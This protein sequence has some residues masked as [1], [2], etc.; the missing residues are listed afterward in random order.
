MTPQEQ[1]EAKAALDRFLADN[2]ELEELSARLATFNIFRALRI[3]DVEIRHSNTLAWLL[4]PRGSHGLGDVALRRVMSNIMLE[5]GAETSGLSA[6]E[7]ELLDFSDVEVRREWHHF[8]LL[9]IV[10]TSDP[11]VVLIENKVRSGVSRRQLE[12]YYK[13]A[14]GQFPAASLLPVLLTLQER[15]EEDEDFAPWIPYS[16]SQLLRVIE[17]IRG[18][19]HRQVAAPVATFLSHYEE[20]LRRL[21]MQD[22]P[23]T[24]LCRAI[25]RKHREAIDLIV[26]YGAVSR[27]QDVVTEVLSEGKQHEI[28]VAKPGMVFFTPQAWKDLVPKW[29]VY[30]WL[31]KLRRGAIHLGLEVG[32]I[33]NP[34]LRQSCV[35]GLSKAGFRLTKLAF[36]PDAKY[37]RFFTATEKVA[38]FDDEEGIRYAAEALLKKA[39]AKI[40]KA[41]DVFKIFLKDV[42]SDK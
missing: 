25:Y 2:P 10:H 30:C 16:Y 3:E 1:A 18:Q 33:P 6:A 23:I 24:D 19:R 22:K 37:S 13:D 9:V 15:G 28:L 34:E 14:R 32:K 31:Q 38:D 39:E 21:T 20:S 35:G 41:T 7:V 17:R 29:W 26:E 40:A 27:F 11:V 8:D 12:K 4:D 36:R 5:S 42:R